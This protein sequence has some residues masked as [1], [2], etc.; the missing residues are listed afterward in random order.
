MDKVPFIGNPGATRT[1]SC[2]TWSASTGSVEHQQRYAESFTSSQPADL[3][4]A[5][6]P[7]SPPA[8][9]PGVRR[10]RAPGPRRPQDR[11]PSR[12]RNP[13]DPGQVLPRR[14][15]PA[16]VAPLVGTGAAVKDPM[17]LGMHRAEGLSYLAWLVE[18]AGTSHDARR[19]QEGFDD[20][21][22]PAALLYLTLR[23]A[24]DLG[25]V[26][27]GTGLNGEEDS[28]EPDRAQGRTTRTEEYIQVD[29][30]R[31][32]RRKPLAVPLAG[33]EAI[34]GDPGP[35]RSVSSS[36]TR[37]QPRDG[38]L[39]RQLDARRRR[40]PARPTAALERVFA[41]HLDPSAVPAGAR[42][43]GLLDASLATMRD[44]STARRR[45]RLGVG[46]RHLSGPM[47]GWRTSAPSCEPDP[48]SSSTRSWRRS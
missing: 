18:A 7:S 6:A 36:P 31:T 33:D 9:R 27:A 11:L 3:L 22:P 46:R 14:R 38:Y 2:S 17:T 8:G 1:R 32:R 19:R 41:E 25:F 10:K 15:Q 28:V 12:G 5:A 13:D 48:R 21:R 47:A 23:H 20:E 35:G 30:A 44:D 45:R 26:E 34:T 4:G 40:L 39:G 42:R 37:Y 24:L 43:C 29:E 16:A